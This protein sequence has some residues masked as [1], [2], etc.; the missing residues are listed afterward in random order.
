MWGTLGFRFVMAVLLGMVG[1]GTKQIIES[2]EKV[3]MSQT[4]ME[5]KIDGH[6]GTLKDI[7]DGQRAMWQAIGQKEDKR[8]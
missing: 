8:K 2:I 4:R 1:Y 7:K 3:S 6:D 5:V